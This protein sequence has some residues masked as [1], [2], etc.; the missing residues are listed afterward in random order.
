[1]TLTLSLPPEIEQYLVQKAI[2]QD[3]SIEDCAIQ[4]LTTAILADQMQ[5]Q[6]VMAGLEAVENGEHDDYDEAG[7]E[8][9]FD[10]VKQNGRS[11][12]GIES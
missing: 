3:I 2:E 11:R 1:M 5:R 12:R 6:A 7:L 8:V 9:L 4:L 10:R